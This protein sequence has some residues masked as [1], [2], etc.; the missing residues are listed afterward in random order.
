ML[1]RLHSELHLEIRNGATILLTR[2][3]Q[4]W[5]IDAFRIDTIIP[6]QFTTLVAGE[7]SSFRVSVKNDS[8][9]LLLDGMFMYRGVLHRTAPLASGDIAQY[10]F[11]HSTAPVSTSLS[12]LIDEWDGLDALKKSTIS[13]LLYEDRWRE[14][15]EKGYVFFV[16]WVTDP[17]VEIESETTFS[18][19]SDSSLLVIVIDPDNPKT[20]LAH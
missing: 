19:T 7:D 8:S 5:T 9:M 13:R 20:E 3:D 16:A 1:P 15:Q 14:L 18:K 11:R 12:E 10:S 17:L 2:H 4:P 6:M